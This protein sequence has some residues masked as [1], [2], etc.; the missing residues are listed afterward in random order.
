MVLSE[1]DKEGVRKILE[2]VQRPVKILFFRDSSPRCQYCDVIEELLADIQSVNGN[3][4]YEVLDA[5]SEEAKRYGVNGGP[6]LLF[7]EKPNIRYRGIPSGHEF[8]AFLED[9]VAVARG[10]VEITAAAAK[11]LAR[12]QEPLQVLVFVTPTCPYCPLAVRVAHHFAY[13]NDRILAEAVEAI[14]WS[15]LAD[16]YRVSAVPKIVVIDPETGRDLVEWEG[17]VPEDVFADYLLHALEHKHGG[18]HH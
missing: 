4:L 12:I 18:H 11:K 17:A 5:N 9:I 2:P 13:V 14:E 1:K 8:P 7:E 10:S 16:R 15:E 6:V 3:V